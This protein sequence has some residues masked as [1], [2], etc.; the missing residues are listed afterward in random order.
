VAARSNASVTVV[1]PMAEP[2]SVST[3]ERGTR[4]IVLDR[5]R[6]RNAIDLATQAALRAALIAAAVDRDVRAIVITGT[7]PVFSAGGD[8]GRFEET[9]HT[10]FRFASHDLTEVIG[11]V[12]RIEKPVVAAVNGTATGAG[13]QLALACDLRIASDRGRF[14]WREGH[15]GLLPSHGGIARLTHLVGLGRA[16]D[17]V[18]GGLEIDAARA[19]EIG[20]VTEV[21]P[22]EA[23]RAAVDGHL[24]RIAHRSPDA[25]AVAKRVLQA[26]AGLPVGTGQAVETLGQS[27]LIGTAEHRER[28][29]RARQR[30]QPRSGGAEQA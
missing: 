1:D 27:L 12:E 25:Y 24:E 16:R 19:Y 14:L 21:V 22:H 8:L 18:L 9:D 6:A 5:P 30:R 29:Q 10:A 3:D 13:A 23:L 26:V 15:L 4:W 2:I 7:D 28:L 17:L 11:L 20:L